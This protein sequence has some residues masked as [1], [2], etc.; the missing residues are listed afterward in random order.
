MAGGR[1]ACAL[2][3]LCLL[4]LGATAERPPADL[5]A[6]ELSQTVSS[7]AELLGALNRT[8]GS[9]RSVTITLLDD[10]YITAQDIRPWRPWLPF[11]AGNRTMVLRGAGGAVVLDFGRIIN[12]I[13]YPAG[14]T[15]VFYNLILQGMAPASAGLG[16]GLPVQDNL[17]ISVGQQLNYTFLVR[18]LT[19]GDPIGN[20]HFSM[21]NCLLACSP[22]TTN[23]SLAFI[24]VLS[25]N[26]TAP[27]GVPGSP[28]EFLLLLA[29]P[30][31]TRI[32]LGA[33]I[34]LRMANWSHWSPQ[35]P[36]RL[37]Q[38][39][40]EVLS[41]D[42][43]LRTLDLGDQP[44]LLYIASDSGLTFN[45]V[46]LQGIAPASGVLTSR[47]TSIPGSPLWPTIDGESGHRLSLEGSVVH[48]II[49]PC[50]AR[51]INITVQLIQQIVGPDGAQVLDDSGYIVFA[52]WGRQE[53]IIDILTN[54]EAGF[55]LY[56][57]ANTIV[58]C[59]EDSAVALAAE[60]QL[61]RGTLAGPGVGNLSSASTGGSS[62][63][64]SG[65]GSGQHWL[66]PVLA[67]VAAT[68]ESGGQQ[69]GPALDAA[70]SSAALGAAAG[71]HGART[72]SRA[73]SAPLERD[74]SAEVW[75]ADPLFRCR[76]GVIE[77]L[78]VGELLGRGAYGRV[79]KGRWNGAIVAVKVV[80]HSVAANGQPSC[81]AHGGCEACGSN[82]LAREPLL[83]MSVSHPNC[84]TTYKLL[85]S[86]EVA[87]PYGPL[88]AGLYETWM[89]LEYCDRGSLA[90]ALAEC[91]KVAVLLCLLDVASGMSYLHSLGIV[92]GDLKP[93]N[94]LLKGVR[95]S[96]RGFQCKLGDFGLSR[97]LDGRSTYIQTGS[98]GTPTHAAPELLRE[99]RLCPAV[100]IY[101]FGV[102]AWELVAGEEAWRG[103]HPMQI[104]LSV[105]QQVWRAPSAAA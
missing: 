19:T 38:H 12:L 43:S 28:D 36:I 15:P 16:A 9:D 79:Y 89:V 5:P 1:A 42:A 26:Q 32:V 99:G 94:L 96:V 104:I 40:V 76:F 65:S 73:G 3:L 8:G 100:D 61:Q 70:L 33:R 63:S 39:N 10:V 66:L 44:Q 41:N 11:N 24:A 14:H 57:V 21:E 90:D 18:N 101:A 59:E 29:T 93:A 50:S 62:S 23:N 47:T 27:T 74:L 103:Q 77:G 83:C 7:V 86:V 72:A 95:N 87:D 92:H 13:Y 82:A 49:T 20:M 45:K 80:E 69:L 54:R 67:S 60:L 55:G 105:T 91:R 6:T 22:A 53:P 64:S 75:H 88:E 25:A 52:P 4:A 98:L 17:T 102:L 81:C 37:R 78:E 97:M 84:V 58:E 68:M 56:Y 35:L 30:C 85:L 48:A 34:N 71:S 2:G 31:V 51:S 46:H